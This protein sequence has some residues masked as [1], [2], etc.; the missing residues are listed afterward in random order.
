MY[1]ILNIAY[2]KRDGKLHYARKEDKDLFE[3]VVG[4]LREGQKAFAIFDM[5]ADD[6][7]LSQIAKLKRGIKI[8]ANETGETFI[9][10]EKIIKTEAGLFSEESGVKSFAHCSKQELSDAIQVMIEKGNFVGI[11]LR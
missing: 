11:N 8:L 6:G 7:R 10:A 4:E 9:E 1:K 2:V 3:K 5:N